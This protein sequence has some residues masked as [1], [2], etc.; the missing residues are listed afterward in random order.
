MRST[1]VSKRRKRRWRNLSC[2]AARPFREP[3]LF[4]HL[5][6][7]PTRAPCRGCTC[8]SDHGNIFSPGIFTD[9]KRSTSVKLYLLGCWR[10]EAEPATGLFEE[11]GGTS[12]SPALFSFVFARLE[13][14]WK[15]ALEGDETTVFTYTYIYI[16]ILYLTLSLSLSLYIYIYYLTLSLSLCIYIYYI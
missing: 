6:E 11:A 3:L 4:S 15:S 5:S 16:Y 13:T 12:G 7:W 2:L 8:L 14:A 10:G 9:A 1:S